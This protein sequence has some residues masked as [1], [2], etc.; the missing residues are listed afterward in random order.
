MTNEKGASRASGTV[1]ALCYESIYQLSYMFYQFGECSD[2]FIFAHYL[3][4]YIR[5]YD[6]YKIVPRLLLENKIR[7]RTWI[8]QVQLELYIRKRA[9]ALV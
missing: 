6:G 2:D 4:I 1:T 8:I 7:R 5:I 9:Y 3:Q